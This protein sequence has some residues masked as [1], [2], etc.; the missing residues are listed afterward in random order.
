MR[1]G[2][3]CLK[4]KKREVEVIDDW[5]STQCPNCNDLDIQH[6]QERR[7]WNHYHPTLKEDND[8]A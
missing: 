8:N 6:S 5:V 1:P 2:D 7:E 4:C 3:L